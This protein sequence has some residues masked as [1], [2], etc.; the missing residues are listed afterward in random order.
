MEL[1]ENIGDHKRAMKRYF[2]NETD[3]A[4]RPSL[5]WLSYDGN[6]PARQGNGQAR[7]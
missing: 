1:A 2:A 4:E 5:P 7:R 3:R 6:W